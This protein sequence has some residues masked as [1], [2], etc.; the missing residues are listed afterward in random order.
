MAKIRGYKV[1][2]TC[3]KSKVEKASAAGCD[4]LIVLDEEEGKGY[5]DYKSVDMV[6]RIM[7]ITKGQGVKCVIDGVGK[8]TSD[9]S[10][11]CLARRG[12][13]VSF[14][15]ASGKVDDLSLLRLVGKSNFVTRP[16]LGD[17]VATRDE[18]LQRMNEV[19]EW[20]QNGNLEVCV[21]QEFDLSDAVKGHQYIEAGKSKGKLLLKI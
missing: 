1:I 11:Q 10:L 14:G 16:K 12:I 13:F 17:Y 21:D 15:N 5:S 8:S 4:E 2:G 20:V 18:L 7:S 19:F 9:I 3:S 6:G